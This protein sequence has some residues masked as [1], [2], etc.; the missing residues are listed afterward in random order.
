MALYVVQM[1]T[2]E[3]VKI[4]AQSSNSSS[5]T[6]IVATPIAAMADASPPFPTTVTFPDIPLQQVGVMYTF[7]FVYYP[8]ALTNC[9]APVGPQLA[10]T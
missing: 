8:H 3:P 1:P 6:A 5:Q 4:A 9:V 7:A 10:T 2:T